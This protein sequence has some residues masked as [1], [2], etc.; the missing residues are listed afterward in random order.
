MKRRTR[1]ANGS[2]SAWKL[3]FLC[4]LYSEYFLSPREIN[5]PLCKVHK[6]DKF[7]T[8]YEGCG[9]SLSLFYLQSRYIML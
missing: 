2:E 9:E 5:T 8:K 3:N 6:T 1:H 7:L 4:N